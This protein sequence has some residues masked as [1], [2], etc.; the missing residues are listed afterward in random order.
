MDL[1]DLDA[2]RLVRRLH[3]DPAVEASWSQQRRIEH[4]RP[5]GRAKHHHVRAGLETVH[6]GEDL[7]ERMLAL[8]IAPAQPADV[9]GAR[10][11]D[12][13]ELVDEDDGRGRFLGL[14]EEIAHARG[15][16][17]D[18]RFYELRRR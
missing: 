6:L 18:D 14:L 15:A 1:Q 4:L 2:P 8:V 13:V 3:R 12:G 16:Y 5:V 7:V 11:A 17:A 9:A 10:A